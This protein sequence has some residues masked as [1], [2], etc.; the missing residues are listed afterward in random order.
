MMSSSRVSARPWKKPVEIKK[1]T[2]TLIPESYLEIPQQRLAVVSLVILLQAYKLYDLYNATDNSAFAIRYTVVEGIFLFMLPIL[3]IPW[4]TFTVNSTVFLT[5]GMAIFNVSLS[6]GILTPSTLLVGFFKLFEREVSLTGSKV[7]SGDV[8]DTASHL[9]GRY[10]VHILPESTAYFNP[11]QKTYCVDGFQTEV[12]IPVRLNATEP[13]FIQLLKIDFD[14]LA[15][16]SF[17]FTRKELRKYKIDNLPDTVDGAK[18]SYLSLPISSPGLYRLGK[19][20]DSS[21]LPVKLYQSDVLV[22]T[23]PSAYIWSGSEENNPHRCIGDV[24]TPKLIVDGVPPLRVKYGRSIK[25]RESLFS[26]QSVQPENFISP[27]LQGGLPESGFVWSSGNHCIGHLRQ[28]YRWTL[29]PL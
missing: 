24:D 25:G 3:R 26:V 27:L 21:N 28:L 15:Q 20:I 29:I 8:L 22:A 23:C 4:L 7:R 11:L 16:T 17:N 9:S 14:S 2:N 6:A 19:V 13:M 5:L 1:A 10:T 18:L 12:S